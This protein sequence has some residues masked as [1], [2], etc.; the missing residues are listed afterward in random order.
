MKDDLRKLVKEFLE[1]TH[2]ERIVQN[3]S[4]YLIKNPTF[5]DFCDWLQE[6]KNDQ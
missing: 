3:G 1:E 6:D 4:Q 2:Q 5:G